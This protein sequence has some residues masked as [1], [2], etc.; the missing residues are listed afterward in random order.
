MAGLGAT[1]FTDV[2]QYAIVNKQKAELYMQIYQYAAEDF[3]TLVDANTYNF[4]MTQY[5]TSLELQLERVLLTVAMH[6]HIDS[7]GGGTSPPLNAP[8]I[9]WATMVKPSLKFTSGATPNILNNRVVI[10]TPLEGAPTVGLRRSQPLEILLT[11]TLPPIMT[12]TLTGL[13]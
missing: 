10:G 5:L 13:A 12:A 9:K 3:L 11:Q 2:E 1:L 8:M 6:T 7:K 4:S